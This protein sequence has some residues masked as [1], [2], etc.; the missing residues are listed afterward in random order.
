[1]TDVDGNA[2]VSIVADPDL[3]FGFNIAGT[4]SGGLAESVSMLVGFRYLL[5]VA[6][7][8]YALSI[9]QPKMRS[10]RS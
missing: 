3:A 6:M 9:W 4:V 10:R 1:M 8:F 7:A 2:P 5:L